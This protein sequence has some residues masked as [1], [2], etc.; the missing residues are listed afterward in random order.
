[1][2]TLTGDPTQ[3]AV[4]AGVLKWAPLG[5]AEPAYTAASGVFSTAWP[6]G[7]LDLG[8]TEDG[9]TFAVQQTVQDLTPEEE[10]WPVA[11]YTTGMTGTVSFS[12]WYINVDTWNYALT[13]GAT[14]ASGSGATL[15]TVFTPPRIGTERAAM[16]GWESDDGEERMIWRQVRNRANVQVPRKKAPNKSVIPCEFHLEKPAGAEP[17]SYVVAGTTRS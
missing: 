8:F 9:H 5:T 2:A 12:L 7:W 15:V 11:S 10:I 4:G 1:M 6:A 3:I 17:W 16:L 13:G 14:A